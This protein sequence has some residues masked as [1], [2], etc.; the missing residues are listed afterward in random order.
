MKFDM[1]IFR[2]FIGKIQVSIKSSNSKGGTSQEDK[3][4]FLI[5][6]YSEMCHPRCVYKLIGGGIRSITQ[7]VYLM[8]FI[9]G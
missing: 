9:R 1:S 8:M 2:N 3:Y 6:S 7:Q 5:K 4:I